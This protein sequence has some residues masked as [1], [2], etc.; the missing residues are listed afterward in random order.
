MDKSMIYNRDVISHLD[1][2]ILPPLSKITLS[3]LLPLPFLDELKT[4]TVEINTMLDTF[5]QTHSLK[6]KY[7]NPGKV[8]YMNCTVTYSFKY[9]TYV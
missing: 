7:S 5:P 6:L 9:W 8:H 2:H 3:Y 4:K 1:Q